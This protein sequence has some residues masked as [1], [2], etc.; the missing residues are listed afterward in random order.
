MFICI[1]A[2]KTKPGITLAYLLFFQ[3]L[4]KLLF[5]AI[6]LGELRYIT[7]LLFLPMIYLLHNRKRVFNLN[8]SNF[9]KNKITW[10]YI[11]LAMYMVFYAFYIGTQYEMNFIKSFL[12]PGIIVF[13]V[14]AVF[15]FNY[16]MYKDL[17][18]GIIIFAVVTMI[19]LLFFKGFGALSPRT[20]AATMRS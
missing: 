7:T 19:A 11:L 20:Y 5:D 15:F 18:Y 4:N 8:I 1:Y 12:F 17:F 13:T 14:G 16:K 6:E 3:R 2:I 10:G 9:K